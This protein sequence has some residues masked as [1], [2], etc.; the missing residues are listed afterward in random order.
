MSQ[1]KTDS[2][3]FAGKL[4]NLIKK[5]NTKKVDLANY[6]GFKKG[7]ISNYTSGKY[8]VPKVEVL[9]KIAKYFDVSWYELIGDDFSDKAYV[10][11][12]DPFTYKLPLFNNVLISDKLMYNSANYTCVFTSPVP[13]AGEAECYAVIMKDDSMKSFG[14]IKS[15]CVIFTAATEVADD[16]IAAVLVKSTKEI[17]IR[18]VNYKNQRIILTSDNGSD[19]YKKNEIF[20]MGKV[21]CG[22]FFPNNK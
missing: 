12:G 6:L 8:P 2:E 4:D 9:K 1:K 3:F 22:T 7:T 13:I 10:A 18:S 17:L 5:N 19:T 15:S 11:E 21:Y 20:I 16:E 14:F